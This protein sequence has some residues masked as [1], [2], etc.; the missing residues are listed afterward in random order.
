M[1]P[2]QQVGN[3]KVS[4]GPTSGGRGRHQSKGTTAGTPSVSAQ[5]TQFVPS[6]QSP[7]QMQGQGQGTQGKQTV[8]ESSRTTHL[9]QLLRMQHQLDQDSKRLVDSIADHCK[10]QEENS[11]PSNSAPIS[12]AVG[13][14]QTVGGG[15]N[16]RLGKG[17]P[18]RG[19]TRGRVTGQGRR[20]QGGTNKNN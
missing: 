6:T 1:R 13:G 17:V 14:A 7:G 19:V 11:T 18:T 2:N 3:G 9:Q 5:S 20:A 12:G 16:G 8:V 15:A 10:G 4:A